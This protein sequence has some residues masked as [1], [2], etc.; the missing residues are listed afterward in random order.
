MAMRREARFS[1]ETAALLSSSSVAPMVKGAPFVCCTMAGGGGTNLKRYFP[2]EL[3]SL[4]RLA[5]GS[6]E[7]CSACI[8]MI[9]SP[10]SQ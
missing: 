5:S 8:P 10:S 3:V 2:S 7:E 6:F 1:R 4:S 9:T